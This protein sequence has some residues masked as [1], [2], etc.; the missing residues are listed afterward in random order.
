[1]PLLAD[2]DEAAKAAVPIMRASAAAMGVIGNIF[3]VLLNKRYKR[4]VTSGQLVPTERDT[5]RVKSMVRLTGGY[6][7][8]SSNTMVKLE[9][10]VPL[11][12]AGMAPGLISS[13]SWVPAVVAAPAGAT[14]CETSD[15]AT[16]PRVVVRGIS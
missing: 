14:S 1:M 5:W 13:R 15:S 2:A 9:L 8:P 11:A 16:V 4:Q 12:D 7:A 6:Q 3:E 10:Y